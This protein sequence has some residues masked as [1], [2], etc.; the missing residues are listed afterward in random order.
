[1][2]NKKLNAKAKGMMNVMNH[3][4]NFS[5]GGI[6]PAIYRSVNTTAAIKLKYR[7][8][9]GRGLSEQFISFIISDGNFR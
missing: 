4:L 3:K 2:S 6:L 1:M 8:R 9:P 5:V 7:T